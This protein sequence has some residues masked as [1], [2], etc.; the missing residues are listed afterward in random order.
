[1][2]ARWSKLILTT[3]MMMKTLRLYVKW[4]PD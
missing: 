2:E 1:M 4:K 3:Y